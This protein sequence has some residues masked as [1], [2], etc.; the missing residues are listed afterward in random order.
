[1]SLWRNKNKQLHIWSTAVY[2]K[3]DNLHVLEIRDGVWE[4][5]FRKTKRCKNWKTISLGEC[6]E[7]PFD[8]PRR[9]R[10]LRVWG[11]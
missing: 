2:Y 3:L 10:E 8:L 4:C 11:K 5:Y 6:G 7:I 1:M 9:I